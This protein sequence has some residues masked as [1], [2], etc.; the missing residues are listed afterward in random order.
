MDSTAEVASMS[1]G[2]GRRAVPF[3]LF[4]SLGANAPRERAAKNVPPRT[5]R[6]E[7]AAKNA[8]P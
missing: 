2:A 4:A 3:I 6:H 7:C 8:P 5:C 1:V